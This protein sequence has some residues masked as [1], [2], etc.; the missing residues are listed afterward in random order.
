[1][2]HRYLKHVV[3]LSYDSKRCVGC[4]LCVEVCPRRVF[5]MEGEQAEMAQKDLCIEC[6][7]CAQNCPAKAIEVQAGTG[8]AAAVII[9]WMTG[10]A[11]SCDVGDSVCC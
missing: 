8:C 3:S 10:K 9:G 4:K 2:K 1:M 11:P 5:R 6:G 7:A